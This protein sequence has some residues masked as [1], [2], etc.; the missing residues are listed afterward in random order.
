LSAGNCDWWYW[1][2]GLVVFVLHA[3]RYCWWL[4]RWVWLSWSKYWGHPVKLAGWSP[5]HLTHFGGELAGFVQSFDACC[6]SHFI[7]LEGRPQKLEECPKDWQLKHWRT[8]HEFLYFSH[9]II[10]WHS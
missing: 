3:W 10:Q 5:P 8:G 7:H 2:G 6:W 1:N 9:L 4:I